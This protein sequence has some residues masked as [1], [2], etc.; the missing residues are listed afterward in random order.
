MRYGK[1]ISRAGQLQEVA[2]TSWGQ[3]RWIEHKVVR[4]ATAGKRFLPRQAIPPTDASLSLKPR[5]A[6]G[7]PS[8]PRS[9]RPRD[10]IFYISVEIRGRRTD[11]TGRK[12]AAG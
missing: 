3:G 1:G 4:V 6:A 2:F 12:S 11:V 5:G 7:C 10:G 9:G 8:H